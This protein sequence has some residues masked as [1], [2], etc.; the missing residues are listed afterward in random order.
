MEL[1]VSIADVIFE[2][3]GKKISY[4]LLLNHSTSF[5][6]NIN[7]PTM[8]RIAATTGVKIYG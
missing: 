1:I 6:R 2:K 8:D 7:F 4:D 3:I 5:Y